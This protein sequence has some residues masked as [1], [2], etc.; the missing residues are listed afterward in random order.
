MHSRRGRSGPGRRTGQFHL[1]PPP[2]PPGL[3]AGFVTDTTS[4]RSYAVGGLKAVPGLLDRV[5]QGRVVLDGWTGSVVRQNQLHP[6]RPYRFGPAPGPPSEK[7]IGTRGKTGAHI[8]D[9][10]LM[11]SRAGP[12]S[13]RRACVAEAPRVYLSAW[14]LRRLRRSGRCATGPLPQSH[15]AAASSESSSPLACARRGLPDTSSEM[16][17]PPS[18]SSESEARL[19]RRR[20]RKRRRRIAAAAAA[21]TAAPAPPPRRRRR[22]SSL[23]SLSDTSDSVVVTSA[24]R[25]P[26]PAPARHFDESSDSSPDVQRGSL[27]VS[28]AGSGFLCCWGADGGI[29]G[30]GFSML[31][32]VGARRRCQRSRW[33]PLPSSK[34]LCMRFGGRPCRVTR[35]ALVRGSG[36]ALMKVERRDELCPEPA[37]VL[38]SITPEDGHLRTDVLHVENLHVRRSLWCIEP[39]ERREAAT[40][41]LCGEAGGVSEVSFDN[42]RILYSRRVLPTGRGSN[43]RAIA[44][45]ESRVYCG[46]DRGYVRVFDRR[47]ADSVGV[48]HRA[49][50]RPCCLSDIAV[51][52]CGYFVCSRFMDGGAA[53]WDLRRIQHRLAFHTL[54][55][56]REAYQRQA[57]ITIVPQVHGSSLVAADNGSTVS[58][59]KTSTAER[60]CDIP[61][62]GPVY[63]LR[64][65]GRPDAAE[66]ALVISTER[67]VRMLNPHWGG[68]CADDSSR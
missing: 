29:C 49:G 11:R 66:P 61:L 16:S 39:F 35:T 68:P 23:S 26:A 3:S 21:R 63:Q 17:G 53:M 55:H 13:S 22:T 42:G 44:T 27:S 62:P 60:L 59:W 41:V 14:T 28:S 1:G 4:G 15:D 8:L 57:S 51:S 34:P 45:H 18:A 54:I 56:P 5:S 40:S 46:L 47:Q 10:L 30:K 48:L 9:V 50:A 7:N 43:V 33:V 67:G 25:A 36:L 65:L 38:A 31:S 24:R 2:V 6:R 52:N 58:L 32:E 19:A 12:R 37:L 64:A 20:G